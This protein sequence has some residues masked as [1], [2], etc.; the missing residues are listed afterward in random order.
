VIIRFVDI[1]GIVAHHCS[2]H[3]IQDAKKFNMICKLYK[4]EG[5]NWTTGATTIDCQLKGMERKEDMSP[6]CLDHIIQKEKE[7]AVAKPN[8]SITLLCLVWFS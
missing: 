5:R 6:G 2:V 1:G 8:R 4:N 7:G 3:N